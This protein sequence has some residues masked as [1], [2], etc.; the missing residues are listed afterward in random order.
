MQVDN[1]ISNNLIT[2]KTGHLTMPH[3]PI[4]H[5]YKILF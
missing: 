1:L 4:K 2:K 3:F 5:Y